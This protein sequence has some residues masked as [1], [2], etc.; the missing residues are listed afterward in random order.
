MLLLLLLVCEACFWAGPH[1]PA[2]DLQADLQTL[3]GQ[4]VPPGAEVAVLGLRDPSGKRTPLTR[5]LDGELASALIRAGVELELVEGDEAWKPEEG[6]PAR[7]W[8]ELQAP[9]LVVGQVQ[10]DSSWTY[11]RLQA[12][13]RE[14]R[15]VLAARTLRLDGGSLSQRLK[16]AAPVAEEELSVQLHLLVLH[17]EGGFDRQVPLEEKGRLQAGD[18]LQLRF[19]TGTDCQVYSWLYSSA[20]QQQDLFSSQQVYK[21]RLQETSWLTLDQVNQVHTFYFV[22]TPHLDEDKSALFDNLAELIRQGQVHD[23][24]GVEKLDQVLG[25]YLSRYVEGQATIQVQRQQGAVGEEEKFILGDGTVLKNRPQLLK[26]TGVLAQALS[27][28]VQ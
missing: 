22:A 25:T 4:V 23:F 20:G 14:E 13:E 2:L 6:L 27:F 1:S 12:L 5:L 8:D 16:A 11:L 7:Y 3:V 21:D 18:R 10:G 9:V 15:R 19:K 17:E 24:A 28:E 26:A